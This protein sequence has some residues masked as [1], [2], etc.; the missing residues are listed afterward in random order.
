VSDYMMTVTQRTQ[1]SDTYIP[2]RA[3]MNG[4]QHIPLSVCASLPPVSSFFPLLLSTLFPPLLYY[5]S[6]RPWVILFF[7]SSSL[8]L[9]TFFHHLR[10]EEPN[11]SQ[12]AC[13]SS[14]SSAR[15]SLSPP[16]TLPC[17]LSLSPPC[18]L[19]MPRFR[20]NSH[21]STSK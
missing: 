11:S 2:L 16:P 5:S 3:S 8:A 6:P 13:H 10:P 1:H 9:F 4:H 12:A 7:F 20:S 14:Q 15:P 17:R 21:S 19:V 18:W